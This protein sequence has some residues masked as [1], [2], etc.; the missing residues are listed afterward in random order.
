LR[1]L[2]TILPEARDAAVT[3]LQCNKNNQQNQPESSN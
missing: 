3:I 1:D 2:G